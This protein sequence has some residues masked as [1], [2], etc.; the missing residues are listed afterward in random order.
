M[1][2]NLEIDKAQS[3]MLTT[4]NHSKILPNEIHTSL[5][6]NRDDPNMYVMRLAKTRDQSTEI[7][8][9]IRV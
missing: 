1:G 4:V 9:L 7:I 6:V 5:W 8:E 2:F 3:I